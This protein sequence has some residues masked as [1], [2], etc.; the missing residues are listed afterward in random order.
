MDHIEEIRSIVTAQSDWYRVSGTRTKPILE[1][2]V[3][4]AVLPVRYRNPNSGELEGPGEDVV[5]GIVAD[6][7]GVSGNDPD[8]YLRDVAGYTV[9]APALRDKN[10]GGRRGAGRSDPSGEDACIAH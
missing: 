9:L 7:I 2:V 5:V 1:T 4:W 8:V 10:S 3:L 6:D